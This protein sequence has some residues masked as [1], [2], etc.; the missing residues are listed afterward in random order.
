VKKIFVAGGSSEAAEV[1][2]AMSMLRPAGWE[3]TADWPEMQKREKLPLQPRQAEQ[4][5]MIL[6]NA[7]LRADIFWL[8]LSKEK[9]EGS[10]TELGFYLGA[11]YR[12]SRGGIIV[13]GDAGSLS[14]LYPYAMGSKGKLFPEHADALGYLL[15]MA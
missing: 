6:I 15:G 10:A 1:S 3:I 8:M 4:I 11:F 7:M 12:E 5:G 13:S 14:R 2:A 9:S